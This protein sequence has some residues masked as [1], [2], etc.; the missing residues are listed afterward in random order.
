MSRIRDILQ[1]ATINQEIVYDHELQDY[2][3]G[4]IDGLK[5]SEVTALVEN[6]IQKAENF[7]ISNIDPELLHMFNQWNDIAVKAKEGTLFH[8]DSIRLALDNTMNNFYI[9]FA[10]NNVANADVTRPDSEFTK[11]LK[12]YVEVPDPDNPNYRPNNIKIISLIVDYCKYLCLVSQKS[13]EDQENHLM[14][15]PPPED[16]LRCT[17]GSEERVGILVR[18]LSLDAAQ[19]LIFRAHN[20]VVSNIFLNQFNKMVRT[21]NEVHIPS[22]LEWVSG[23]VP[24]ENRSIS[25]ES[26][27]PLGQIFKFMLE[28]PKEFRSSLKNMMIGMKPEIEKIRADF[29]QQYNHEFDLSDASYGKLLDSIG[30]FAHKNNLQ[31]S[32]LYKEV[33][34]DQEVEKD[35]KV[36]DYDQKFTLNHDYLDKLSS[37]VEG[38]VTFSYLEDFINHRRQELG[39]ETDSANYRENFNHNDP[40]DDANIEVVYNCFKS[41]DIDNNLFAFNALYMYLKKYDDKAPLFLD[42]LLQHY[43]QKNE[44]LDKSAILNSLGSDI[45][46]IDPIIKD[47]PALKQR[48]E[49]ISEVIKEIFEKY[50]TRE[51]ARFEVQESIHDLVVGGSSNDLLIKKIKHSKTDTPPSFDSEMLNI[52]PLEN[53]QR[54][55]GSTS[56]AK[57]FSKKLVSRVNFAKVFNE[58]AGYNVDNNSYAIFSNGGESL[59]NFQLITRD[60]LSYTV[61]KHDCA[62]SD[63]LL[64][65]MAGFDSHIKAA[66]LFQST[67]LSHIC[68][69]YKKD[70][71]AIDTLLKMIVNFAADNELL[72]YINVSVDGRVHT[73]TQLAAFSGNVEPLEYLYSKGLNLNQINKFS[74]TEETLNNDIPSAIFLA[75]RRGKTEVVQFFIDKANIANNEQEFNVFEKD[76]QGDTI[77]TVA[78]KHNQSQLISDIYQ[79]NSYSFDQIGFWDMHRIAEFNNYPAL[80]SNLLSM[81]SSKENDPEYDDERKKLLFSTM[82][83]HQLTNTAQN[84]DAM[85]QGVIRYLDSEYFNELDIPKTLIDNDFVAN[86]LQLALDRM[87]KDIKVAK[88][89]SRDSEGKTI[90]TFIAD[91]NAFEYMSTLVDQGFIVDYESEEIRNF[92]RESTNKP[93]IINTLVTLQKEGLLPDKFSLNL[94]SDL[95]RGIVEDIVYFSGFDQDNIPNEKLKIINTVFDSLRDQYSGYGFLHDLVLNASKKSFTPFDETLYP[96]EWLLDTGLKLDRYNNTDNLYE[97]TPID[98]IADQ[99]D[100][101]HKPDQILTMLDLMK[102]IYERCDDNMFIEAMPYKDLPELVSRIACMGFN[103]DPA[104]QEAHNSIFEAKERFLGNKTIINYSLEVDGIT[105]A[106]HA[107]DLYKKN[108]ISYAFETLVLYGADLNQR[109]NDGIS[110]LMQIF[111]EDDHRSSMK[112]LQKISDRLG[113]RD[114]VKSLYQNFLFDIFDLSKDK[115]EKTSLLEIEKKILNSFGRWLTDEFK[116]E[117]FSS[118]AEYSLSNELYESSEL[119]Y[120]AFPL[121]K[122]LKDEL[123]REKLLPYRQD[124]STDPQLSS[125]SSISQENQKMGSD[126]DDNEGPRSSIGSA[127]SEQVTQKAKEESQ[128]DSV[129]NDNS[130]KRPGSP[131]SRGY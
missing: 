99:Y 86:T 3:K 62:K 70:D 28:S 108:D 2:V 78:A 89:N 69:H 90:F 81:L 29:S 45:S 13:Q 72:E 75:A 33:K 65:C 60:C 24:S 37:A 47:V 31:L 59:R 129:A 112:I 115:K 10:R 48:K 14:S 34:K 84:R 116:Q 106:H 118:L 15:F 93:E 52:A 38:L 19:M 113:D 92:I 50:S 96:I 23:H 4:F 9:H 51:S 21:G 54:N 97:N 30:N 7:N 36:E 79:N 74:I 127:D 76:A 103:V 44:S 131:D 63:T 94:N 12:R 125:E 80:Y 85:M 22:F 128:A 27:I 32:H 77:F 105:A 111:L 109:N 11:Y 121:Q 120:E 104:Q 61:R 1:G 6:M 100:S 35:K 26:Q 39:H 130:P 71:V 66:T 87:P 114:K 20:K 91:K 98:I 55:E 88:L 123:M 25:P 58:I 43:Q 41:Q 82:Y 119:I 64:K 101:I 95:G 68:N 16:E 124:N 117:L 17:L 110:V 42:Q 107:Y 53:G 40:L 46:K 5:D 102:R 8:G 56:R 67:A 57:T 73:P 126:I 18:E 83:K 49:E 122:E